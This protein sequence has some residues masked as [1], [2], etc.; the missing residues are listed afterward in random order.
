MYSFPLNN[1]SGSLELHNLPIKLSFVAFFWSSV[2][3][4]NTQISFFIILENS[5][6]STSQV[7]NIN[8]LGALVEDIDGKSD[9]FSLL[10][11]G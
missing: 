9:G 8:A 11:S 5:V 10:F 1:C 4:S 3:V 2:Y 7:R 6:S